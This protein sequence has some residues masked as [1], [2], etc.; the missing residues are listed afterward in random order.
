MARLTFRRPA[1]AANAA[2]VAMPARAEGG[3]H[4]LVATA[5]SDELPVGPGWFESSFDLWQG[6]EVREELP[7]AGAFADLDLWQLGSRNASAM[8]CAA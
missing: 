4:H 6:L 2:T 8:R 1:A 7:V 5:A 3:L